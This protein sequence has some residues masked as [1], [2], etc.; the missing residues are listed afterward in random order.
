M[1]NSLLT[2]YRALFTVCFLL[3]FTFFGF[4]SWKSKDETH[5]VE[6]GS[7]LRF[8]ASELKYHRNETLT[9]FGNF[10]DRFKSNII[11]EIDNISS[12]IKEIIDEYEERKASRRAMLLSQTEELGVSPR[13][14]GSLISF[15]PL[16]RTKRNGTQRGKSNL[17]FLSKPRHNQQNVNCRLLF[18]GDTREVEKAKRLSKTPPQS[19]PPK[20]F[21]NVTKNCE[22]F[23]H[24]RGYVMDT[25]TEEEKS[26]PLAFGIMVYKSPEQF[27]MLLRAIYRPQN[28]YCVHVDKK[29]PDTLFQEFASIAQCFANVFLA[30]TR[31]T[32][33]WGYKSV[34]TQELV[35]MQ[36]L[37]KYK[38]WKYFINL[39]GQEFPLRTNYELVKILGIYN[40]AND[41]ESTIKT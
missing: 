34:L 32:V 22:Q 9:I 3:V 6:N 8:L 10:K 20:K 16:Y 7:P 36:D 14:N 2:K 18:E 33:H 31:I 29:T 30:S 37:L 5:G 26:F 17:N 28:V 24:N 25:L 15:S 23:V 4:Q 41:L 38:K 13:G 35:C 21:A 39:T 19:V 1:R 12:I 11:L 40:G 27:E